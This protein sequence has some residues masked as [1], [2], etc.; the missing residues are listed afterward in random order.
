MKKKMAIWAGLLS[1]SAVP[2][3]AEL[4][5]G[6]DAWDSGAAPAATRLAPGITATAVTALDVGDNNQP[7]RANDGRGASADGDWGSVATIPPASVEAGEGIN[8]LCLELG[9][10]T[11][12]GSITFTVTNESASD[13]VVGSFNF[14]AYAFRPKAARTYELSVLPGGGIT[15]GVIYSSGEGE[16]PHVAGAWDHLAHADIDHSLAELEDRTLAPGESVDF[17]LA[18]SGGA[19][20]AA[21]GHDLWIDNVAV[22]RAS[23]PE[24]APALEIERSGG[25]LIFTWESK[26]RKLYT[27]RSELDPLG[28]DPLDWPIVGAH[29]DIEPT[30]PENTLAIT[31]PADAS[32]FYV[33]EAY[34]APPELI[35]SVDFEEGPGGWVGSVLAG[36]GS[37]SW[38]HGVPS[39]AGGE[40][41]AAANSGTMVF[42]T[43]LAGGYTINQS[44]AL[45]SPAIDLTGVEGAT[46]SYFEFTDIE[47][48]FDSGEVRILDAADDSLIA[49]LAEAI[50]GESGNWRAVAFP[51]P[52]GALN[53]MIKI[54]FRLNTDAVDTE[55]YAGWYLDDIKITVP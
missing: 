16:I 53:R 5:A 17:L 2:A 36:D 47:A 10:A 49:L 21:G 54:E 22:F 38:M 11:T 51:I 7:W 15:A 3:S 35:H 44:V 6:W 46:L 1:V 8:N 52:A 32:R 26:P 40:G 27:L 25:E 43:N 48:D 34:D 28:S 29:S 20:D 23:D 12:G 39:A 50:D 33:L 18:V 14:D 4:I 13:V 9:N 55:T 24:P 37:T 41:P 45:T 42:G 31:L 19:G 30:P